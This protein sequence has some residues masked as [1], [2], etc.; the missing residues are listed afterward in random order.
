LFD[1]EPE[2]ANWGY[3]WAKRFLEQKSVVLA[4]E[5]GMPVAAVRPEVQ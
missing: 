1:G 3:G 2:L 4:R 5:T